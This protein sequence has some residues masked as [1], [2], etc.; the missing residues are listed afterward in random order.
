MSAFVP[1][2]PKRRMIAPNYMQPRKP[3]L[4]APLDQESAPRTVT[5]PAQP[6]I[7]RAPVTAAVSQDTAPVQ[8]EAPVTMGT[9]PADSTVYYAEL[10][11]QQSVADQPAQFVAEAV[12]E[13]AAE[14]AVESAPAPAG[15]RRK[16]S[17]F[18]QLIVI[19]LEVALVMTLATVYLY[20][21]GRIDLPVE[22]TDL[23]E[24]GLALIP[25]IQ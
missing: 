17:V 7:Q 22:V 5:M 21:T 18:Q 25:W 15:Q 8:V 24:K 4:D 9:A 3:V 14:P 11:G 19:L 10:A 20:V 1:T 6:V 2:S 16:L 12:V 13:A 23:I